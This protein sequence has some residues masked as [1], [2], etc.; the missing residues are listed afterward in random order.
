M[1]GDQFILEID[2]DPL[3]VHLENNL[4]SHC[5]WRDGIDIGIETDPKIFV[6]LERADLT[7]VRQ[8]IR[9]A[10]QPMEPVYGPLAG[11]GAF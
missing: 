3:V 4:L 11:G 1:A 7:T 2:G 8:R 6:D 9:Q 5:P 10:L